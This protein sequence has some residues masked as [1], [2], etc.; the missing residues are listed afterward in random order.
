MQ[1]EEEH[2]IN[3]IDNIFFLSRNEVNQTN[4]KTK[5]KNNDKRTNETTNNENN[6]NQMKEKGKPDTKKNH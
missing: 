5:D 4:P 2:F 6:F 3:S 1:K